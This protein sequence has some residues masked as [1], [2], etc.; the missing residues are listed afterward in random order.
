MHRPAGPPS[1][2]PPSLI[3]SRRTFRQDTPLALK[4]NTGSQ[5]LPSFTGMGMETT[6]AFSKACPDGSGVAPSK[7]TK[8]CPRSALKCQSSARRSQAAGLKS[9]RALAKKRSQNDV[10]AARCIHENPIHFRPPVFIAGPKTPL[11]G[12][13]LPTTVAITVI[14]FPVP[15]VGRQHERRQ[16]RQP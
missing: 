3:P 9:A 2:I 8:I 7:V 10:T 12:P 15:G 6:L 16:G 5:F 11:R 14:L 4:V 1:L 13:Y